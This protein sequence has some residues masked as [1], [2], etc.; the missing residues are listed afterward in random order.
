[1]VTEQEV[2]VLAGQAAYFAYR[3]MRAEAV[4]SS[5]RIPKRQSSSRG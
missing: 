4:K 1:M 2:G 5:G 3:V